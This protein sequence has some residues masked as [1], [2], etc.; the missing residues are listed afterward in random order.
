[1]TEVISSLLVLGLLEGRPRAL[2]ALGAT[3]LVLLLRL[4][5]ARRRVLKVLV[6]DPLGFSWFLFSI[7][8]S[9]IFFGSQKRS[10][11]Q[12]PCKIFQALKT[13]F[14][15]NSENSV[16]DDRHERISRRWSAA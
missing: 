7:L 4:L 14:L 9:N 1:M 13:V 3:L 2:A 6:G 16:K 11:N 8:H 15:V 10:L 5:T 12:F